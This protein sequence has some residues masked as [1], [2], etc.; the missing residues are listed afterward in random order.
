MAYFH[1][2]KKKKLPSTHTLCFKCDTYKHTWFQ[3]KI[4]PMIQLQSRC[5]NN[6]CT[7]TLLSSSWPSACFS[8]SECSVSWRTLPPWWPPSR[9]RRWTCG[10]ASSGRTS[11]RAWPPP[12]RV[13]RNAPAAPGL[14]CPSARTSPTSPAMVWGWASPG[15]QVSGWSN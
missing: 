11:P 1:M 8:L 2:I 9:P 6:L 4:F 7:I 12:G 15:M 10:A 3:K 5:P 13:C 14:R